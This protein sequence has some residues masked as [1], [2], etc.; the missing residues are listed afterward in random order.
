MPSKINI[1]KLEDL[2]K[3]KSQSK[4]VVFAHYQGLNVNQINELRA[5]V[6]Q[7]GGE[8]VVSKNTLLRLAFDKCDLNQELTGPTITVFA[9]EDEIA[10]LKVVADFSKENKLPTF[11]AGYFD[12]KVMAVDE[13]VKLSKLPGKLELQAKVVSSIAAPLSGIVNVL[14]GNLRNLVYTLKTIQDQKTN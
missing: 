11:T 8:L 10:P 9:Y 14:Q 13:V 7:A 4:S 12:S 3:K 6:K 2:N 1:S 5:K